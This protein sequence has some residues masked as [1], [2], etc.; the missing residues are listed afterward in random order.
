MDRRRHRPWSPDDNAQRVPILRR[1]RT[2]LRPSSDKFSRGPGN[3]PEESG[4]ATQTGGSY[5]SDRLGS[6]SETPL[7]PPLPPWKCTPNA[8]LRATGSM[9]TFGSPYVEPANVGQ[10]SR[11]RRAERDPSSAAN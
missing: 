1:L 9:R 6:A 3:L 4:A 11:H 7:S 5:D 2:S 8:G 10:S